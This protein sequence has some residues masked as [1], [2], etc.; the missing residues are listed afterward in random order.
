MFISDGGGLGSRVYSI[1]IIF[2]Y[3]K[4]KKRDQSF[5]QP[6]RNSAPIPAKPLLRACR[7]PVRD[8]QKNPSDVADPK[9]RIR[10]HLNAGEQRELPDPQQG[11]QIRTGA[12]E[13][14][15]ELAVHPDQN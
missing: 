5:V 13:H 15:P 6:R 10:H 11:V 14:S 3:E 7:T 4:P 8:A 1:S 9:L 2:K 12:V